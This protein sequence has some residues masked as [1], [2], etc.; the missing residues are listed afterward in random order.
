MARCRRT[1]ATLLGTLVLLAS[2]RASA[3][4]VVVYSVDDLGGGLF[5]YNFAVDNS[6]G[7]EALSGLN[8]LHGDTVFGLDGTSA[9]GQPAGW[10]HFAPLPP[11][12]HDLDYFSLAPGSDVPVGGVRGGYSFESTTDPNAIGG[13][14]FAVEGIGATSASQIELGNAQLIPEPAT[15]LL[16]LL[17]V[18]SLAAGRRMHG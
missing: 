1:T 8:V 18:T 11:L 6:G 16:L 5:R 10:S 9:I 2:A 15:A 4:P 12:V 14:D 17:G 7:S 13:N 3:I